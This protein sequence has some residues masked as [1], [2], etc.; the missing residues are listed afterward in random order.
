MSLP[1]H[2]QLTPDALKG[3]VILITGA[4]DGL[5]RATA[6]AAAGCGATVVLLGRT[7][8]KLEATYDAIEKIGGPQPGIVP[9]NLNG[10][11]WN[12]HLGVAET[13]EQEFGRLDG[14]VHCAAYFTGFMRLAELPPKEWMDSVQTNLTAAYVL[15]R[16]VLPL[17]EK[18]S[19]G[20]VVFVTDSAARSPKAYQGAYGITKAAL[21]AMS[22]TWALESAKSHPQLRFNTFNPGPMRT[23]L[24][25]KGF[26]GEAASETP[27]PDQAARRLIWLL[28]D[29]GRS[30][31]GLAV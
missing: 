28:S 10:A 16:N 4:G 2:P 13:L 8:K 6:I 29:A 24:R 11:S 17:L 30:L 31:S 22:A 3:R 12:D 1:E 14:L 25:V 7:I 9:L 5:G 19:D 15:T 21:E 20:N 27:S 26:S 18:S 23:A